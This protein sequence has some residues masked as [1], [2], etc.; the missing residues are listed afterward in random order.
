MVSL[1]FGKAWIDQAGL[2]EK[3]GLGKL[4]LEKLGSKKLGLG[5]SLVRKSSDF[6]KA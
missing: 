2:D 4:G 5:K 6:E 1:S 3:L